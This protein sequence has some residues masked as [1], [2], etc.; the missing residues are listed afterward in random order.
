MSG[1]DQC[2]RCTH[3]AKS[4][5]N[6]SG[7]QPAELQRFL[8]RRDGTECIAYIVR[9]DGTMA[10]ASRWPRL[11]FTLGRARAAAGW[12][13]ALVLPSLF[14][15]CAQRWAARNTLTAGVPVPGRPMS[16]IEKQA[17]LGTDRRM[18]LG[19][20][21]PPQSEERRSTARREAAE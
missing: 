1:D 12:F 21:A 6:L 8:Q 17:R 5:H 9:A 13:L 3:C 2:R 15:G 11:A 18:V 7:M 10:T 19:E 16:A 4:V 14:M 20:V